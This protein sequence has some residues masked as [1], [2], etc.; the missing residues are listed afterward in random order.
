M[1]VIASMPWSSTFLSMMSTRSSRAC[2][3]FGAG[4]D[5]VELRLRADRQAE[6]VEA[7]ARHR[8]RV[9]GDEEHELLDVVHLEHL[10]LAVLV[11]IGRS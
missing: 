9:V 2:H 3:A 8:R 1:L 4:E 10:A 5:V 6:V 11:I 7:R